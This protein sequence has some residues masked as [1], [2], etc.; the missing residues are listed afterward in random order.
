MKKIG[1]VGGIGPE[2]TLDY[3]KGIIDAFKPTYEESS[4]YPEIAIESLNIKEMTAYVNAGEWTKLAK[5]IAGRFEILRSGGSEMGAIASNTP[6]RVFEEIQAETQLPLISIV[7]K[8]AEFAQNA[9]LKTCILL[10]TRFTMESDFYPKMFEKHGIHVVVPDPDAQAYINQKLFDEI[11][12][13]IIKEE[14]KKGFL[15]IVEILQKKYEADGV[16]MGCTELPMILSPEDVS[17]FYLNT[18][19]IHIQAIVRAAK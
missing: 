19:S 10:G 12:F 1:I 5:L 7:E 4:G 18:T 3:Y 9:G 11:E 8:T 17:C 16:I 13:G 15:D 6:H 2:S 14:T